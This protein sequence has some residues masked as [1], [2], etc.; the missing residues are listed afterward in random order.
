MTFKTAALVSMLCCTA[1][2]SGCG[3]EDDKSGGG[4]GGATGG[5]GGSA[6][7]GSGGSATGGSGGATG[8]SGGT[9]TGGSGGAT[10]GSGGATGGSGGTAT[11]GSGGTATG[12]SGGSATGGS[13]GSSGV[14]CKTYM[15]ANICTAQCSALPQ[16]L[17]MNTI[18]E[19]TIGAVL[20][21]STAVCHVTT[22]AS[23]EGPDSCIGSER[24]LR[25][26]FDTVKVNRQ[27]EAAPNHYFKST[28]QGTIHP[29]KDYVVT[30]LP[31]AVETTVVINNGSTASPTDY[32]VVFKFDGNKLSVT[33]VGKI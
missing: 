25:W 14:T 22:N 3:A 29:T 4:S 26:S 30:G 7:G 2:A 32:T 33:S 13:G 11:G 19:N 1:L 10:G 12:G 16:Y 21:Y 6:T 23:V 8:G 15:G 9:A 24:R 5:S 17:T 18:A 28:T 31:D 20:C 27:I